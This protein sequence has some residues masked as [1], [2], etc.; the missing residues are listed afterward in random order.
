MIL[1]RIGL[2]LS[3]YSNS[4]WIYIDLKIYIAMEME[5]KYSKEMGCRVAEAARPPV[6][7]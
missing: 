7:V 1:N 2:G 5:Y 6:M 3:V 4:A